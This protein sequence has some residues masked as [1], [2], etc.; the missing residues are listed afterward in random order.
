[1]RKGM[2]CVLLAV[3]A[4]SLPA[5]VLAQQKQKAYE[6]TWESLDSRPI[7]PWFGKAK[8]GIFIHW[9]VY[10]VPAW[11]PDMA[12]PQYAG[13]TGT[14]NPISRRKGTVREPVWDFHRRV[15][16]ESFEYKQFAPMF[17]AELFEPDQWAELF[18]RSG[19]RYVVLT[20]KFNTEGFCMWPAPN[21]KDWNSL[22][23]GPK[24]DLV[25]DLTKAVRAAG[26]KMGLYYGW[27]EWY[28]PR[29]TLYYD[30]HARFVRERVLP[31]MKDLLT[32][33]KP[34]LLFLDGDWKHTAE[35]LHAKEFLAWAYNKSPC[36][37]EIVVNDRLGKGVRG[38]HGDYFTTERGAGFSD[39]SQPWEENRPMS[40]SF[41]Y[42]RAEGVGEYMSER[43]LILMLVDMVS[44]GGN[45]LLGIGPRA[46]GRIPV[47][48]EERLL[49]IGR[50]LE[51]N[52]EAIHGTRPWRHSAQWSDGKRP[53]IEYGKK[54][55]AQYDI[56]QMTTIRD[57]GLA[58]VEAFFTRKGDTLYAIVP[59]WPKDKLV[60]K[61]V[62]ASTETKVTMLGADTPL[63]WKRAE[64]NVV[65]EVPRLTVDEAPC[66]HAYVLKL[67]SVAEEQRK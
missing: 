21:S 44:R 34:S 42:N 35:Q 23:V 62:P 15:Y 22:A 3:V 48:M 38:H 16:G 10:S 53:E 36:R 2:G 50:W 45:F 30:D 40:A 24:R 43:T 57:D 4:C 5:T 26:L 19:A 65:I 7:P 47:I 9:G 29:D 59:R 66:R 58:Y 27:M 49:Q 39:S 41:S 60:L 32:R 64:G 63:R 31:Q 67:T 46:D 8:F 17:K 6:P 55:K 14:A 56:K 61:R 54:F 1:M 33:Y 37:D 20:S 13:Q 12:T 28:H 25:G 18:R 52:G 51:V 11:A